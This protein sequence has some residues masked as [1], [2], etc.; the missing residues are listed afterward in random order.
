MEDTD[1]LKIE[2]KKNNRSIRYYISLIDWSV[3]KLIIGIILS[4]ILIT[5]YLIR[6]E[7]SYNN[8]KDKGK[9]IKAVVIAKK[10]AGSRGAIHTYYK[11]YVNG[12]AYVNFSNYDDFVSIGDSIDIVYLESDPQTN[13]SNTYMKCN[14]PN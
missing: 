2:Q 14:C 11:F 6:G 8:L 5:A 12:I 3:W 1:M 13:N 4:L 10:E 7:L 9:C